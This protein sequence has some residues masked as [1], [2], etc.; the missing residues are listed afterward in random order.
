MANSHFT[1]R[2]KH[3]NIADA[4]LYGHVNDAEKTLL[5]VTRQPS[6]R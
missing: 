5:S 6:E 3:I 1:M 2:Q 4:D